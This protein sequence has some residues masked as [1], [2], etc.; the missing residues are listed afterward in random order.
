[1]ESFGFGQQGL[2]FGKRTQHK[3]RIVDFGL[4]LLALCTLLAVSRGQAVYRHGDG[5]MLIREGIVN[6]ERFPGTVFQ[7]IN[8]L[9]V[10]GALSTSA[11]K[12]SDLSGTDLLPHSAA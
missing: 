7:V 2:N 11:T 12:Q 8:Y 3:E 1:V 5:E 4:G 9:P 10:C 6:L